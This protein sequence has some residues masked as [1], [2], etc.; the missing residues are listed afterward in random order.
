M[1]SYGRGKKGFQTTVRFNRKFVEYM[2]FNAKNLNLSRNEL[3]ERAV[4]FAIANLDRFQTALIRFKAA[5]EKFDS[6]ATEKEIISA[7]RE[8]KEAMKI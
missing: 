7:F 1:S 3:I 8:L 2:D 4:D 5:S 6:V